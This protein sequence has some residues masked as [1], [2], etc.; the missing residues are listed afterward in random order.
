MQ[1]NENNEKNAVQS[2]NPNVTTD[3]KKK[4]KHIIIIV[5]LSIIALLMICL[6][7]VAG[8]FL[9]AFNGFYDDSID[10]VSRNDDYTPDINNPDG[11]INE[12]V[13]ADEILPD[14]FDPIVGDAT[15]EPPEHTD[16][17]DETVSD[18]T[19]GN[20]TPSETEDSTPS[21]QKPSS[22][23]N[24]PSSGSNKPYTGELATD[25][26][27]N[28]PIYQRNQIDK[29]VINIVVVGRDE[30]SYY[31]R[32]DS[33]MILS[34]NKKTGEVKVI[35]LLRDCY[36]PIEGHYWN[37]LGHSLSY[38]GMGLYINTVNEVLKL[39]IQHYIVVDFGGLEA[40]VNK[41]G[42]IEVVLTKEEVKWFADAYKIY[43]MKVGVNT[44]DGY[45]ALAH[46]RN[47]SLSG[48][49]FERTRRQRDVVMA[50]YKKAYSQGLTKCIS[51]ANEMSPYLKMNISLGTC[52]QIV[53][54]VFETGGVDIEMT[55]MPFNGT[56]K[57]A[58]AKPPGYSGYMSIV[59]IDIA[60]N[61]KK[62]YEL[63]YG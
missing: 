57:Y 11:D 41:L 48:S 15:S 56:W 55:S 58:Y 30:A 1:N 25:Y 16:L 54:S 43:N 7:V 53:T 27:G 4:K 18:S 19:V 49:D 23:S 9:N 28:I 61:R 38:G 50:I 22:G 32:A 3:D 33:A 29:D 51:L 42:G 24:K 37:K 45:K 60:A 20:N 35:S 34:Y 31:G 46:A 2:E 13:N 52:I 17:A 26:V 59:Q 39:D 63:I 12:T 6:A 21:T 40:I 47:R 8:M 10:I 5:I 44:M 36:V 62:I 14:D